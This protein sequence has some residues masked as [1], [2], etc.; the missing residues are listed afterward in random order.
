MKPFALAATALVCSTTWSAAAA[1]PT[2]VGGSGWWPDGAEVWLRSERFSD[3]LP[4]SDLMASR[5]DNLSPRHDHTLIYVRDE[6]RVSARWGNGFTLSA[7]ARQSATLSA[8]K[9]AARLTQD[10]AT[11][12]PEPGDYDANV[13]LRM[14]GFAGYG[15]ELGSQG[16][17]PVAGLK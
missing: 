13:W 17:W 4:L 9:G 16:Q 2:A 3:P 5:L 14:R 6:A 8:N 7:L 10:V 12:G 1:E 11:D 15:L